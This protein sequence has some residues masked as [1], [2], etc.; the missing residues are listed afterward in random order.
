MEVSYSVISKLEYFNFPDYTCRARQGELLYYASNASKIGARLTL[1]ILAHWV[2]FPAPGPPNTNTTCHAHAIKCNAE[3]ARNSVATNATNRFA[4]TNWRL[5]SWVSRC[6]YTVTLTACAYTHIKTLNPPSVCCQTS[7]NVAL[8]RKEKKGGK[9]K[10]TTGLQGF[11][12]SRTQTH[13]DEAASLIGLVRI[14]D[15]AN[16]IR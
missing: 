2:P 5:D 14:W 3:S 6:S 15:T 4:L 1:T 10:K 8:W 12:K 13:E 7:C 16:S 11:W 9:E